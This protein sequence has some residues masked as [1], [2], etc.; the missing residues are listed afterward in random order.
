MVLIGR[1]RMQPWLYLTFAAVKT[2]IWGI[3]FILNLISLSALSIILSA[4]LAYVTIPF[5][6]LSPPY[7]KKQH[8]RKISRKYAERFTNETSHNY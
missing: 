6:A 5:P 4:I 1:R 3:M 7:K 8:E 2:L